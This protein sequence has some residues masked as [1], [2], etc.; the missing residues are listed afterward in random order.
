MISTAGIE[1]TLKKKIGQLYGHIGI[2]ERQSKEIKVPMYSGSGPHGGLYIIPEMSTTV[3]RSLTPQERVQTQKT[4]IEKLLN[5]ILRGEYQV[6]IQRIKLK[7]PITVCLSC[8][9]SNEAQSMAE[10]LNSGENA[11]LFSARI[12]IPK[13]TEPVPY[14]QGPITYSPA[15]T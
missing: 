10:Y 4:L 8:R 15:T 12:Q 2:P 14:D 1:V 7:D 13:T 9:S 5:N 6:K 3:E 11:G